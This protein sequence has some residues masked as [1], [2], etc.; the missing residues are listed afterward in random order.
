M[1]SNEKE[2]LKT[3][4]QDRTPAGDRLWSEASRRYKGRLKQGVVLIHQGLPPGCGAEPEFHRIEPIDRYRSSLG[5]VGLGSVGSGWGGVLTNFCK[6]QDT[7]LT[8]WLIDMLGNGD[9][10]SEGG[11]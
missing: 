1:S 7:Y 10:G 9:K 11:L 4:P 6:G 2:N 8:E 3:R 5:L